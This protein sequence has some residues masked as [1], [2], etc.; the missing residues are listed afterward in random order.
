[1]DL[2]TIINVGAGT[3]LGIVGWFARQLWDAVKQ[4]KEDLSELREQLPKEYLS[5]N[6]FQLAYR[7]IEDLLTRIDLKLDRKQDK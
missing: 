7:R 3:M 5:K 6:D 4:L 2:Q 1:M